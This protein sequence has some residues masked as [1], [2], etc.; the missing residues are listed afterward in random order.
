M[1]GEG[2][3]PPPRIQGLCAINGR[4]I[5]MFTSYPFRNS[6]DFLRRF[7]FL[8]AVA[9]ILVLWDT[10][11]NAYCTDDGFL[12]FPI[13]GLTPYNARISSVFMGIYLT[14]PA[15]TAWG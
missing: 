8:L 14:P 4:T 15:P 13:S 12:A 9:A 5:A 1:R 10:A 2:P 7:G 3:F 11:G 6:V